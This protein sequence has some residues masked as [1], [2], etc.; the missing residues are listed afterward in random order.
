MQLIN[1]QRSVPTTVDL[2]SK[3]DEGSI[4]EELK[5]KNE[6]ESFNADN[7]MKIVISRREA[8]KIISSS[9]TVTML[10]ADVANTLGLFFGLSVISIYEA[11]ERR[12][13]TVRT[14]VVQDEGLRPKPETSSCRF[15]APLAASPLTAL[16]QHVA[17]LRTSITGKKDVSR[18]DA[19][20]K[21]TIYDWSEYAWA[22][23]WLVCFG[24]TI[25]QVRFMIHPQEHDPMLEY[26]F[27]HF[28]LSR[29]YSAM[30][31][32]YTSLRSQF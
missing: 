25:Q 10:L 14:Q 23:T 12:C 13:I 9:Y 3:Q 8:S 15:F 31:K 1:I 20:T 26:N 27:T 29:S 4:C 6:L 16:L 22:L 28:C 30:I 18:R 32:V 24:V 11:L 19:P 17:L 5:S 21:N 2:T 7:T